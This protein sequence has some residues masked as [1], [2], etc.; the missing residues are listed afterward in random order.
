MKSKTIITIVL[1]LFVVVSVI[2]LVA[3]EVQ[4]GHDSN[5]LQQ[6]QVTASRTAGSIPATKPQELSSHSNQLSE[7]VIV[8][9]FYGTARCR[10]CLRIEAL[11]NQAIQD[12]FADDIKA[13]R[14]QWQIVNIDEPG[15]EHFVKDY[16]LYTK[17]VVVVNMRGDKLL[18]WKNLEQIWHL[19]G[20]KDAFLRYVTA[21][22]KSYLRED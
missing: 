19:L 13:G 6:Q 22:I 21:E 5:A 11:T 14:L 17:S 2:F 4:E 20:D 10:S 18:G 9:Y 7:K 15:N 16:G 3:K 1:L 8:Y 12:N